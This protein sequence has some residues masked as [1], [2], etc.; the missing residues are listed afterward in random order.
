MRRAVFLTPETPYPLTGGGALRCAS[1]LHYLAQRY[2]VDIIVF[3]QPGSADPA[4]EIPPGLCRRITIIDLPA[5]RR[6]GIARYVRNSIRLARRVPPL[7]DRFSGFEREVAAALGSSQYAIGVIEHFWCVRYWQQLAPVCSRTVMD[8]YDIESILHARCGAIESGALGF[9]HRLFARAALEMEHEWLPRFSEILTTSPDDAELVLARAPAARVTVYPNAIPL[10][11]LPRGGRENAIVFSGNLEYH[12]NIA[13]VRFFR[14]QVW[15]QLRDRW[16]GLVWRLVG[17][18]AAAVKR[19]TEGDDRI[20][21]RGPVENA[22]EELARARVAV[23][24]I[25]AASGTRLKILEAWGAGLPVV[26]T[27]VGAEGLPVVDGL[28]LLLA[29]DANTFADAV[30]RLLECGNLRQKIGEAGRML[31]ETRFTWER[32]WKN[33][34]L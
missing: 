4:R 20:E 31:L 7:V 32:A 18:N 23:V 30:S 34:N 13:A 14:Q 1:L 12:P 25:L 9:S 2:E 19:W 3:R 33:L 10:P 16:P 27:R 22:I 29:D 17:K 24:P 28:H 6:A 11:P 21:V 15:P 26:S 5:H 8:L